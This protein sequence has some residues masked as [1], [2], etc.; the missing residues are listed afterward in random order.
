MSSLI[1]VHALFACRIVWALVPTLM[2]SLLRFWLA[3]MLVWCLSCHLCMNS[4]ASAMFIFT[5]PYLNFLTTRCVPNCFWVVVVYLLGGPTVSPLCAPTA[6]PFPPYI[7]PVSPSVPP[8]V[9]PFP[10]RSLCF[11]PS[12]SPGQFFLRKHVF[13]VQVL[14]QGNSKGMC[15]C[16]K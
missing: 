12:P 10:Q 7:S 15:E 4:F 16:C 11:P 3:C 13:F 6:S 2:S 14:P 5:H 8:I 1:M 9:F